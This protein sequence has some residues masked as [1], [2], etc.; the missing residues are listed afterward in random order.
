MK[1]S[2]DILLKHNWLKLLLYPTAS[3]RHKGGAFPVLSSYV[4]EGDIP[5]ISSEKTFFPFLAGQFYSVMLEC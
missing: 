4:C 2:K 1:G 5:L 3:G